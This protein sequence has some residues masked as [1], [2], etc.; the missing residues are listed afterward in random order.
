MQ[1]LLFIN[2][3]IYLIHTLRLLKFSFKILIFNITPLYDPMAHDAA[4]LCNCLRVVPI[5][6]KDY[7]HGS[8]TNYGSIVYYYI[9]FS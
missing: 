1:H 9:Q 4:Q 2:Y 7:T 8:N 6:I 5:I 3:N